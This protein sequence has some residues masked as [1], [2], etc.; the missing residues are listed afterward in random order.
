MSCIV[1]G[2]TNERNG[3]GDGDEF[4][5]ESGLE[6]WCGDRAA[7]FRMADSKGFMYDIRPTV[8][9]AITNLIDV[10]GVGTASGFFPTG[11]WRRDLE[12]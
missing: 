6:K 5:L 7:T 10:E 12:N 9:Q 8:V 1:L 3:V 4:G 11:D 2:L